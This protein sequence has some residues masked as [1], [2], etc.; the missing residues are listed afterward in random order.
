VKIPISSRT[1]LTNFS[2]GVT[3]AMAIPAI[4]FAFQVKRLQKWWEAWQGLMK[5]RRVDQQKKM[6]P[7]GNVI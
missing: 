5:R 2:V 6:L 3:V 1:K 7:T 4:I